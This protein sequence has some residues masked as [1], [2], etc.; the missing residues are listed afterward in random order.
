VLLEQLGDLGVERLDPRVEGE[1][2]YLTAALI[3]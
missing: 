1:S 3:E 2:R